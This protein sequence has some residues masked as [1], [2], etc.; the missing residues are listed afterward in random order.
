VSAWRKAFQNSRDDLT[1]EL[2]AGRPRKSTMD[3][4][5]QWKAIYMWTD[6]PLT[7]SAKET[8]CNSNK[9]TN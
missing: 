1:D 6:S 8:L 5:C 9:L 2:Q 7:K 3:N 4:I